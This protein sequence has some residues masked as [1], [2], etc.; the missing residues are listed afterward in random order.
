MKR[1][2]PDMA[3]S[4]EKISRRQFLAGASCALMAFSFSGCS[5]K[6]SRSLNIYNYSN[7]IAEN[8]IANFKK[9]IGISVIYDEFSSQDVLFARLKLGDAYDLVVA[10]DYMLRRL[11][12]QNLL[13]PIEG[14]AL[15]QAISERF[16][17]PPWDPEL[18]W[19]VPYLWG[20][21]GIG[22]NASK[23]KE[24]PS[25][26]DVLWDERYAQRITMLDEKRDSIGAALIKMGFNG[27]SINPQELEK[28]KKLLND[29]KK[30]VRQYTCDYIDSLA[31]N[32]VWLAQAW[33]GDVV[34]ARASNPLIEYCLPQEGSF[35][36]VDSWCIPKFAKH[37]KEATEFLNYC[38]QP[39]TIAQITNHTGFPNTIE[40]SK[41]YVN[42]ELLNNPLAYPPEEMLARTYFQTDIGANEKEWDKIW[43]KIKFHNQED[44]P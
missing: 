8:T 42:K 35:M 29:Q 40:K 30:L 4:N 14:F 26:W 5:R 11:I 16:Q 9:D 10:T 17:A 23:V 24:K 38:M 37:R 43:G 18:R 22:Y 2:W 13:Y 25:S 39:E 44:K 36:F 1:L 3:K 20:T 31:R 19:S 6:S 28:A 34:R 12:R 15:K 41:L 33:S 7:Y 32:E 21:T 27:N